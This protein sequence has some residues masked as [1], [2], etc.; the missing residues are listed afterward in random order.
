MGQPVVH[1]EIIGTNPA[2]LRSY[3]GELFGWDFDTSSPVAESVSE[4][5]NYG[6]ADITE[7][8]TGI[9]GG[10]GGG[11]AYEP[12]TIFYVGVPDVEAALQEAE[13]LGGQRRM[14]PDRAPTG[15]VVGHFTDP[16][17]NLIGVAG[18]S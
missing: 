9:P 6:F 13:R 12:H 3:Y 8:G 17:G 7:D 14:G 10:V 11:Q 15:L 1:F 18:T 2:K 5:L 4:P 16:E